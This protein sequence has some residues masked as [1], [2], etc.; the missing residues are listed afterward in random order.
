[1]AKT[2][3]A[4]LRVCV[5]GHTRKFNGVAPR[6]GRV[7]VGQKIDFVAA[8]VEGVAHSSELADMYAKSLGLPRSD[9]FS[10][11]TEAISYD[12]DAPSLQGLK[13]YYELADKCGLIEKVREVAFLL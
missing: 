9:L 11:L 6:R 10:Y 2:H 1:M 8:K 5:L 3:R 4:S 13:L 12:L 7:A